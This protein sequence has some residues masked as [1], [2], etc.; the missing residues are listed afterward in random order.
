MSVE[1][2][3]LTDDSA[4]FLIEGVDVAFTNALRRT[5]ISEVPCM[6]IDDIFIFDNSSVVPDEVL[7]H[8]MGLLPLRTDLDSYVIPEKCECGSDLG[9]SLCR[10]VLTLDVEADVGNRTVTSGDLISED[11]KIV[12]TSPDVPLA[13]LAPGQA[14]RLE[15]YARLGTGKVHAKWQPVSAA[16][17]QNIG[18]LEIDEKRCTSCAKCVEACPRGV[19]TLEDGRVKIVDIYSCILCGECAK[20]CPESPPAL[21]Q[22]MEPDIYLFTVESTGCL[23][24]ERI[25]TEAARIILTKL[26]EFSGK[27]KKGETEDEITD[28]ESVEH[29]THRLYSIGTGDYEEDEEEEPG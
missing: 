7:A 17:Y 11:P 29:A 4:R 19:L 10:V 15:A 26:D 28:F 27:I 13:K 3:S 2:L 12:P 25:V 1:I 9:C 21:I 22:D 5:M 24:P 16:I 8:R 20:A 23:P 6:A 14:I 18:K